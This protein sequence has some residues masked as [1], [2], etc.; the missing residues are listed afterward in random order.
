[1]HTA[2]IEQTRKPL[3]RRKNSSKD[4]NHQTSSNS[5]RQAILSKC[6]VL[7]G[8]NKVVPKTESIDQNENSLRQ[9]HAKKSK[10]ANQLSLS[11]TIRLA[12]LQK[13]AHPKFEVVRRTVTVENGKL[14]A[15]E[16]MNQTNSIPQV[17]LKS[18]NHQKKHV[19]AIYFGCNHSNQLA[20]EPK[21][22]QGASEEQE[23][24]NEGK[25]IKEVTK[26]TAIAPPTPPPLPAF[27]LCGRK[28]LGEKK[29]VCVG[30]AETALA[31]CKMNSETSVNK[32]RRR[33]ENISR[34]LVSCDPQKYDILLEELSGKLEARKKIVDSV[35][36]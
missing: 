18:V 16:G 34:P 5:T 31:V 17:A 12:I 26:C 14:V 36:C 35:A 6:K 19:N 10:D 24:V 3:P 15:M 23:I 29:S 27:L 13:L 21:T 9:D 32:A 1:M 4:E 20:H 22:S 8:K 33:F 30:F 28:E 7:M 2:V 25:S 11:N